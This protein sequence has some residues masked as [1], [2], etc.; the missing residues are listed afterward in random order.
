LLDYNYIVVPL[1]TDFYVSAYLN[2]E[3]V[4]LFL[5]IK[6]NSNP[7]KVHNYHLVKVSQKEI[8]HLNLS[9]HSSTHS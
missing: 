4:P 7:S 6:F 5:T 8:P 2:G 9:F 1:P 3:G